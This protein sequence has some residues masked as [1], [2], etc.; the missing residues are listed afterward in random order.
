MSGRSREELLAAA[1]ALTGAVHEVD[2][3]GSMRLLAERAKQFEDEAMDAAPL[4]QVD[5]DALL[6][7]VLFAFRSGVGTGLITLGCDTDQAA[8]TSHHVTHR[9]RH[10]PR[11]R[12]ELLLAA[13]HILAGRCSCGKTLH[14]GGDHGRDGGKGWMKL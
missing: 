2:H 9:I 7:L 14:H 3:A 13:H 6:N 5:E 4:G 1:A 12:E 8:H 11:I 10:E